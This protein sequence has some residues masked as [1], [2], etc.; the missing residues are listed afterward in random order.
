MLGAA[1]DAASAG[2]PAPDRCSP[3][4]VLFALRRSALRRARWHV[5]HA[6]QL[7]PII[8]PAEAA[9]LR[10]PEGSSLASQAH[11]RSPSAASAVR[12]MRA[13]KSRNHVD[14][15]AARHPVRTRSA[16]KGEARSSNPEH[17]RSRQSRNRSHATKSAQPPTQ[18][19]TRPHHV[20]NPCCPGPRPLA[21]CEKQT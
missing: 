14:G 17:S 12:P 11:G 1:R 6:G 4:C 10:Q 8:E 5:L 7:C 20:T 15:P 21:P 16:A 2:S 9:A 13:T 3:R 19:L 18:R